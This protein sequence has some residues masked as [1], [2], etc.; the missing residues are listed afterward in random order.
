MNSH[1][2]LASRFYVVTAQQ[3]Q[4]SE[5]WPAFVFLPHTAEHSCHLQ[6]LFHPLAAHVPRIESWRIRIAA[7]LAARLYRD[8]P[9]FLRD[10]LPGSRE[11]V[12]GARSR[13]SGGGGYLEGR[14]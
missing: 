9:L 1:A 14:K 8:Q 11:N 4:W 13:R 6:L 12:Q 5:Y 3:P 10:K 7:Q 2:L